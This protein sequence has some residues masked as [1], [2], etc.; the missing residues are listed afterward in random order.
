MGLH[1]LFMFI[2]TKIFTSNWRYEA[3]LP[4]LSILR[5][6]FVISKR[7]R[8]SRGRS[9]CV[10]GIWLPET[11]GDKSFFLTLECVC[12]HCHCYP[13][14]PPSSL[15]LVQESQVSVE[16]AIPQRYHRAIMGPKGCRIQHITREHEVQIKFPER[17]DSAA[18]KQDTQVTGI[19]SDMTKLLQKESHSVVHLQVRRLLHRKMGT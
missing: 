1:T 6:F 2:L 4:F 11:K 16:V 12:C 15:S 10:F 19:S 14:A 13:A 9:F 18:G 17:E 8:L 5:Y 7:Q 3:T